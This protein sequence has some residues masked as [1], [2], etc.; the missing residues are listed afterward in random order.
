MTK[1]MKRPVVI[2]AVQWTGVNPIEVAEFLQTGVNRTYE[3]SSVTNT[4]KI[5][6]LKGTMTA[7]KYDYIIK[8]IKGEFYPC[9]PEIFNE[10]YELYLGDSN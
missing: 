8:G 5:E 7:S 3:I 2:E 6:T 9:K 1:Y 4:V 10:T